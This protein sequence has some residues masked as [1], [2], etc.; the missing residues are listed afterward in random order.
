MSELTKHPSGATSSKV[1]DFAQIPRYSL[2]RLAARFMHGEKIHGRDNWKKGLH[3]KSYL[4]DRL[5]HVICHTF[6]LIEELEAGEL[7]SDDN[8]AAIMWG[9]MFACE[10]TR[11]QFG[12]RRDNNKNDWL[13]KD[14]IPFDPTKMIRYGDVIYWKTPEELHTETPPP[15]TKLQSTVDGE[16]IENWGCTCCRTIFSSEQTYAQH[17]LTEHG[18]FIKGDE[19]L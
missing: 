11:V 13:V 8:A 15:D 7:G 10:A 16:P 1:Y 2:E 14:S 19:P 17:M 5:N 4:I 3:D 12:E 6:A 9:G 18:T